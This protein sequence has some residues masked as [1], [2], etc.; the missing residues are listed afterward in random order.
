MNRLVKL[1]CIVAVAIAPWLGQ[2]VSAASTEMVHLTFE[3]VDGTQSHFLLADK[4]VLTVDAETVTVK[5]SELE[6][7]IPRS[8]MSYFHFTKFVPAGIETVPA[9]DFSLTFIGNV[10]TVAGSGEAQMMLYDVS[11]I[12]IGTYGEYDGVIT[13]DLNNLADGI[14]VAV[15]S[16]RPAIKV[17]VRH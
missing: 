13:A 7:R 4:P 14:Y 11:G 2:S 16:G 5:S 8:E 15:I 6:T 3:H 1:F 17:L 10:L 9:D 12:F